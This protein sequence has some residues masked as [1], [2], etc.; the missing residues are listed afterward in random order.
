MHK[1]KSI[2]LETK[3]MILVIKY[4]KMYSK[5]IDLINPLNKI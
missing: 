2:G 5:I 4:L 3:L 1:I